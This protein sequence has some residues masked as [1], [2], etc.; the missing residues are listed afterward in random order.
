MGT[1]SWGIHYSHTQVV[2]LDIEITTHTIICVDA[3]IEPSIQST[4]GCAGVT[5]I[6]LSCNYM[7]NW[8]HHD[9]GRSSATVPTVPGL[10][11]W[12]RVIL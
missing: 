7:I 3:S 9:G 8:W 10:G 12:S 5:S 4:G 2:A 1:Q 11:R 6:K